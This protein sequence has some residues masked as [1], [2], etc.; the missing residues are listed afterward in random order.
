MNRTVQEAAQVGDVG[1]ILSG[2]NTCQQEEDGSG[3]HIVV[4]AHHPISN[5]VEKV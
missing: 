3:C 5:N 4:G 1:D 2:S